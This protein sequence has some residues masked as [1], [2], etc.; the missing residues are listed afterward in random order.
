M[1]RKRGEYGL[2]DIYIGVPTVIG[3]D[4][5]KWVIEIPLTDIENE[6]MESSAKTLKQ[7]LEKSFS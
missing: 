1:E 4:G 5:A 6:R 2:K 3:K 7:I